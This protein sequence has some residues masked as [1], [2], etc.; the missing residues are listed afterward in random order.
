MISPSANLGCTR[1][2]QNESSL[3]CTLAARPRS[4]QDGAGTLELPGTQARDVQ[5]EKDHVRQEAHLQLLSV[6][7]QDSELVR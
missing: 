5:E 6:L 3:V 4:Q 2:F 1:S 7:R